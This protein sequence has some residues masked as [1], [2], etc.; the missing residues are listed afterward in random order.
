MCS[1]FKGADWSSA[2][3]SYHFYLYD[4][5]PDGIDLR[6]WEWPRVTP[7]DDQLANNG[8][9]EDGQPAMNASVPVGN[10]YVAFGGVNCASHHV[11][12]STGLIAGC[13]RVDL[14]PCTKGTDCTDCGRSIS[15][16]TWSE[17]G[18]N[19]FKAWALMKARFTSLDRRRRAQALPA[20]HDA[21]E[22]HHLERTLKAATS[23][24]LPVPWLRALQ[25]K[26]HWDQEKVAVT[27]AA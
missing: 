19:P 2:F 6:L 14:V 25:I 10:Y 8:V 18:G 3:S 1:P 26:D 5:T 24:H 15:Q 22:M 27:D 4:E 7:T 17:A 16:D 23:Y 12:L 9:C 13:G 21:N 11:N 20:V